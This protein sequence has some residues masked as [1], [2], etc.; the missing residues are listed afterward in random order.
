MTKSIEINKMKIGEGTPKICVP[1]TGETV[2]EILAQAKEVADKKPDLI[3]WRADY[4]ADVKDFGQ[5][6]KALKAIHKCI[7]AIPLIFTFRTKDEGGEGVLSITDYA[8]LNWQAARR[9]EVTL[10]DVEIFCC[11]EQCGEMIAQIHR[12]G[13]LAIASHHRFDTTPSEGEIITILHTMAYSSA[14][15]LKLA[16]MPSSKEDV[17]TLMEATQKTKEITHKP[18][19]T[20]SMGELGKRSRICGEKYGSS[21]TFASVGKGSAPGQMEIDE[22]REEL[23]KCN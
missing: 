10:V 18:L 19:I 23:S 14:D 8:T 13:K 16:V 5:V 17:D 4:F 21:V 6:K 2:N 1:I 22:L 3:E 12:A 20:V 9:R 15:I 11:A 7:K